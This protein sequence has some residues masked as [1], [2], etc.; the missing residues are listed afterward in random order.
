MRESGLR[1][2]SRFFYMG[3]RFLFIDRDGLPL[4]LPVRSFN[5][6][7]MSFPTHY[8]KKRDLLHAEKSSPATLSQVGRDFLAAERYSDALDFFEKAKDA[9]GIAQIKAY[10]LKNGDTFLIGRLDRYDRKLI[11]PADWEAAARKAEE[12]NKSSMAAFV[13][14]KF[15]P[16][17]GAATPAAPSTRPGE[18]PGEA[19]LSEV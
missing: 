3:Y 9:D 7:A 16:K 2:F 14:R 10:A 19:P 15:A 12:Q 1:H 13:A 5:I 18:V 8:I 11:T 4:L 17:P 6:A